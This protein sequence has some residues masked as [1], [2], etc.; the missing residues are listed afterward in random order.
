ML[1]AILDGVPKGVNPRSNMPGYAATLRDEEIAAVASLL[2]TSWGHN[3]PAITPE[4]VRAARQA[5]T[6]AR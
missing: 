6:P 1:R 3:A 5:G 4:Q 2:R